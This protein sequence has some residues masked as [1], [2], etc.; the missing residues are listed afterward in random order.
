[1]HQKLNAAHNIHP[2]HSRTAIRKTHMVTE[3]QILN[4]A[5]QLTNP[6]GTVHLKDIQLE[7]D[8]CPRCAKYKKNRTHG[9]TIRIVLERNGYKKVENNTYRK[10][11]QSKP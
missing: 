1:M 11:S 3:D 10:T 7:L 4:I 8:N 5:E 2:Y 9:N 6:N